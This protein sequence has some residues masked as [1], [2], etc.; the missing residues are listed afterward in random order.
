M[1]RYT[2][3]VCL[4]TGGTSGIGLEIAK[5]IVKEGGKVIVCSVDKN[6][7]A[8]VE[9]IRENG[10]YTADGFYCDVTNQQQR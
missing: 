4:I 1:S 10:K 7:P 3:K 9:E 8:A 6:I 2:N 5:G